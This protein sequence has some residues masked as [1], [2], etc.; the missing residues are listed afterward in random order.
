V[1]TFLFTSASGWIATL[2]VAAE[3]LLPYLLRR[4]RLS[5]WLGTAEGFAQ[6]YLVR[7]WPHYWV[8]YILLALT[9]AHAWVPM[10]AGYARHANAM[11]LWMATAAL[12]ALLLQAVLG[13]ALQDRKLT[14]RAAIR[15]WHYWLMVAIVSGVAAHVWLNR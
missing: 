2:L 10:Q 7:M 14:T 12:G 13:F 3:V 5:A 15:R 9:L 4:S 1:R 6:P 8:G 11:G